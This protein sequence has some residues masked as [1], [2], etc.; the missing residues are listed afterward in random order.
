[1][2]LVASSGHNPTAIEARMMHKRFSLGGFLGGLINT[3]TADAAGVA[4]TITQV[5][6]SI[7]DQASLDLG[8]V[9]TV[10]VNVGSPV[11]TAV[12]GAIG[13]AVTKV[14]SSW[15]ASESGSSSWDLGFQQQVLQFS[16]AC[17]GTQ[18]NPGLSASI[19]LDLDGSTKGDFNWEFGI[20]TQLGAA[21]TG[22]AAPVVITGSLGFDATFQTELTHTQLGS[23]S[24]GLDP[25]M[26]HIS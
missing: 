4:A 10:A 23:V 24:P 16:K 2:E 13:S 8:V 18:Y 12:T 14:A 3:I 17:S 6:E 11:V 5:A 20:T 7:Y 9:E 19:S 26:T 15:E 1:M 25:L 22:D 21:I